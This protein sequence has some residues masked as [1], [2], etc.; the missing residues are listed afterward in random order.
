MQICIHY[1][2]LGSGRFELSLVTQQC[3][4]VRI[5]FSV[6]IMRW[7]VGEDTFDLDEQYEVLKY[8]GCGAYGIVVS[9][10]DKN[11]RSVYFEVSPLTSEATA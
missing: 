4:E 6:L 1:L 2:Q 10:Y 7:E 3:A 8:L 9:V 5:K 11:A